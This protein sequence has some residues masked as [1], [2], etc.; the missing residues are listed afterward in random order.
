MSNQN[1]EKEDKGKQNIRKKRKKK[2]NKVRG[3][4]DGKK[5]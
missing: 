4:R 2:D 3:Q 5:K 1:K